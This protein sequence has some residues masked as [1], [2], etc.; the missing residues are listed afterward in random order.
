[1]SQAHTGIR[2]ESV[3]VGS[4]RPQDTKFLGQLAPGSVTGLARWCYAAALSLSRR[5]VGCMHAPEIGNRFSGFQPVV[6]VGGR[7]ANRLKR[8]KPQANCSQSAEAG[9]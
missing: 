7:E 8:L 9:R 1:M 2:R 6:G 3:G 4:L 5:P